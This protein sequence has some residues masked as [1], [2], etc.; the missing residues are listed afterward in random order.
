[1]LLTATL[2]W[3]AT[4]GASFTSDAG[5][6]T[7]GT[8]VEG[9]LAVTDSSTT[10]TLGSLSAFTLDARLRLAEGT[11]ISTQAG[12]AAFVATW[13]S[14]GGLSLGGAT[15]A[16][17]A[18]E[19]AWDSVSSGLD[20]VEPDLVARDGAW[21][22]YRV[23]DETVVAATSSDGGVWADAGTVAN[24]ERPDAVVEGDRVVLYTQCG[25]AICRQEAS[26]GLDFG[27]PVAV[28]DGALG[29]VALGDDGV[30]R[31]WYTDDDGLQLATSADGVSYA[32][33][34]TLADDG[35][36]H[37]LDVIGTYDAA[38]DAFDGVHLSHDTNPSFTDTAGDE[39]PLA[40]GC[41]LPTDP[42]L[43]LAGLVWRLAVTC[44]GQ[45]SIATGTP[46]PGTWA[47]LHIEWDG[48]DLTA[49]WGAAAPLTIALPSADGITFQASGTLELDEVVIVYTPV[50]AD[51]ADTA[52]TGDT[53]DTARDSGDSANPDSA[54]SGPLYTAADLTGEPGGC[55][56]GTPGR[57]SALVALGALALLKIRRRR[58]MYAR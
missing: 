2:A 1:M 4:N 55:G 3:A 39:G 29:S 12:D 15:T 40:L 47:S 51:T 18:V 48:T 33:E 21:I 56:C 24:G 28:M 9:V 37:A 38:W 44:D 53:A 54:D 5:D 17:P 35:R 27:N 26:D 6:W 46:T 13:G 30:W 23:V 11:T 41:A 31:L 14:G 43:A 8:V 42:A 49:T 36:L 25:G 50:G 32:A 20:G 58:P 7:G 45:P 22:L 57:P 19:Q 16:L 10:L 52:D 34:A